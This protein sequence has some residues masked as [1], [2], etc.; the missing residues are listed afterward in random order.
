MDDDFLISVGATFGR[1]SFPIYKIL[2]SKEIFERFKQIKYIF[3]QCENEV[4]IFDFIS[5]VKDAR[6]DYFKL[7]EGE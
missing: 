4:Q 7:R 3:V 6:G 2:V 1:A 5:Y